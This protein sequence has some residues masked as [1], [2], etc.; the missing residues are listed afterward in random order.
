MIVLFDSENI[1]VNIR[2]GALETY[3][4]TDDIKEVVEK[5][6]NLRAKLDSKKKELSDA[7][8]K[9]LKEEIDPVKEQIK[10]EIRVINKK[11]NP[12][13]NAF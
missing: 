10:V 4:P 2:T 7:Y 6:E 1:Y 9:F 11:N 5:S 12:N 13:L 3:T 8:D